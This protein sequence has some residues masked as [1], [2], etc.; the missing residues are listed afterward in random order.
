MAAVIC[1]CAMLRRLRRQATFTSSVDIKGRVL[2]VVGTARLLNRSLP[3]L[4]PLAMGL[5]P[6]TSAD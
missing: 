5:Y 6:K 4:S 2:Y 3:S 1:T